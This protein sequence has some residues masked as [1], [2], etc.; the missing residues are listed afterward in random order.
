MEIAQYSNLCSEILKVMKAWGILI[1]DDDYQRRKRFGRPSI[2]S[3]WSKKAAL[4]VS[5]SYLE[6]R[7]YSNK[8]C[9]F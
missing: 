7:C 1:E 8:T 9:G 6:C 4:M 3:G 5:L 2:H